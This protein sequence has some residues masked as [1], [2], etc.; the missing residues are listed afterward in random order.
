MMKSWLNHTSKDDLKEYTS[1]LSQVAGLRP[2]VYAD[3]RLRGMRGID[4]WTGSGLRFTL[5]PDRA[6]DIG[7][8]WFGDKPVAWLHPAAASPQYFEPAGLGWLRTYGGGLLTTCGLVHIGAPDEYQGQAFGLHGRIAHTPAENLRLWQEWQGE[9]YLLAVE[10][11]VRQTVLFGEV[12][13]LYRRI[14]TNL[15]SRELRIV[16]RVVNE[17]HRPQPH[18][19]L[20]HCNF[21]F[22]IV[23]PNSRLVIDD[24]K[25]EPRTPAAEAGL[26]DH[27]R[28]QEPEPGYEE[29]VFFHTP[30]K[31][32][33]GT[34]T[35]ALFNPELKFGVRLNWSVGTL[36]ILTQ[37]KMM[38][39]GEYVCGLEPATHAMAPWE[40]LAER[41]LP[42]VLRPG[43]AIWHELNLNIIFEL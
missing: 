43:E 5:W 15:G 33:D 16:D 3:G 35:A 24:V 14:E 8:V 19:L 9:N 29:Q 40:T 11:E 20:Y 32:K 38:G 17:G 4:G 30:K 21:G 31:E 25:V 1:D 2:F 41:N 6:L 13:T 28:F 22:P 34:A 7:P 39:A 23:S 18:S 42:R 27:T 26:L 36:P 10:G 12:L 37:W